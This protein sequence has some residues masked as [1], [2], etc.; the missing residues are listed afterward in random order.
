MGVLPQLEGVL[1]N[2][3]PDVRVS[4]NLQDDQPETIFVEVE[5]SS[6]ELDAKWRNLAQLQGRV[7]LCARNV[8]RRVRLI[9]D[10]KLKNL[11]GLATDL[12]TLIG[13]KVPDISLDT[14][15]WCEEW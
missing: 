13:C 15:L 5:M 8:L 12:E 4:R 10:C 14:P 6:K 1:T 2:S 7:A 3:V 11:H 9:G